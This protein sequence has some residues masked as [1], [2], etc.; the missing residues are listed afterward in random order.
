[1][2]APACR[3]PQRAG[4]GGPLYFQG[5]QLCLVETVARPCCGGDATEDVCSTEWML[6]RLS[7]GYKAVGVCE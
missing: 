4:C 1:M 3:G 7:T 5:S 6:L 2:T